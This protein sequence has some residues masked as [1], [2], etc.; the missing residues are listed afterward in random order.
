ME[1]ALPGLKRLMEVCQRSKLSVETAPPARTPLRAGSLL[2]GVPFDPIL[3]KVYVH[4]GYAAFGTGVN[5]WGLI[6][7]DDQEHGLEERNKWWREVRWKQLG[8]PVIVFGSDLYTYAT[9]PKLAD[10]QGRQPVVLVD[11]HEY[12]PSVM[13]V[14]S[15][16]DRFFDSYSRYF[17]ILVA[18]PDYQQTGDSDLLF[19]WDATD[20]LA[21]DERLVELMRA[22]CFDS[23]VKNLDDVTRRWAAKVMG[24]A[25]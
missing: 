11:T 4:L 1:M 6:R 13:P 23:L 24:T 21:R 9:V 14:A 15:N 3:A 18:D 2:E 7:S 12:N 17:E 25:S 8:E 5:G 20:I 10:E 19:P 22:G 16:V